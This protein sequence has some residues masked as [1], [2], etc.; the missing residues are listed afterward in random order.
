MN[1][2]VGL[3]L[4]GRSS[5][6]VSNNYF[7][8]CYCFG[9]LIRRSEQWFL[10]FMPSLQS[11]TACHSVIFSAVDGKSGTQYTQVC[12]VIHARFSRGYET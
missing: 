9:R 12:G 8:L 1:I 7:L 10:L 6:C 3:Y 2:E 4:S 11:C 5:H